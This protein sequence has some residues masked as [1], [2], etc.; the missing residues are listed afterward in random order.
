MDRLTGIISKDRNANMVAQG[1]DRTLVR[2]CIVG[3]ALVGKTQAVKAFAGAESREYT[4]TIFE[5]YAGINIYMYMLY[6]IWG[7]ILLLLLFLFIAIIL[8]QLVL[9]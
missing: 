3:D 7:Y 5:N 6:T 8:K 2:C 1:G 4:P 9:L